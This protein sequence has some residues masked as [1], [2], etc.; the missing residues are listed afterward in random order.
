MKVQATSLEERDRRMQEMLDDAEV[1][2]LRELLES[3]LNS[4]THASSKSRIDELAQALCGHGITVTNLNAAVGSSKE[5]A[6]NALGD[7]PEMKIGEK[8]ELIM[9]LS[10]QTG[11]ASGDLG[12]GL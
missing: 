3:A 1:Q 11:A 6:W 2:E 12:T 7:V 10:K 4:S 9:E 8:L 5:L